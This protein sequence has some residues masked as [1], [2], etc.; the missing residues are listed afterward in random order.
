M[1]KSTGL[2]HLK[3]TCELCRRLRDDKDISVLTY[4]L[5]N[6]PYGE[7]NLKYCNDSKDCWEKALKKAL[8][9]EI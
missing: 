3:W 5:K 4:P 8:T 9:Q 6:L 1:E 2:S 7:R